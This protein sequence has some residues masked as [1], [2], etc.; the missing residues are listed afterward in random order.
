[1]L[2]SAQ[3]PKANGSKMT[4]LQVRDEAITIS[5]TGQSTSIALIWTW[6]LLS[7]HP[8]VEKHLHDELDTVLEGRLPNMADLEKL[9]Y[10]RMVFTESMRLYPQ[11]WV[12]TRTAINDYEVGGYVVPSGASIFISQYVMHRDSRY[13]PD[14]LLFDPERWTPENRAARPKFSYF[15]FGAGPRLCIGEQFAWMEGVLIIATLAKNWI[16]RLVT[17]Q[18]K[19]EPRPLLILRPKYGIKMLM[20]KR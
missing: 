8:E 2:L 17:R 10:T 13:F 6:Y 19:V 4:D 16:V 11:V 5:I 15:P 14:P 9:P 7:K 3:D 20:Q 1:M 12:T 18:K